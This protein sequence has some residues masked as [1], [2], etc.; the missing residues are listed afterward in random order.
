MSFFDDVSRKV[1][2][3]AEEW[4]VQGKAEKLAAEVDKVAHEAKDKAAELADDNRGKIRENLDKA[5]AKIDER[6]EGKYADKVAKA[7][8]TVAGGVDKLAEQRPGGP[9]PPG[10]DA[11]RRLRPAPRPRPRRHTRRQLRTAVPCRSPSTSPS[12]STSR[13][14]VPA[15]RRTSRRDPSFSDGTGHERSEFRPLGPG[16]VRLTGTGPACKTSLGSMPTMPAVRLMPT[17]DAP[18]PHRPDPR[19]LRQGP[20]APGRRD[21][22]GGASS[23]PADTFRLLGKTGLLSLPYPEE[24]G[25]GGQPYEVYLQVVEEIAS[26]WMSVAVGVSVHSLTCYP[27]ASWGSRRAARGPAARHARRRPARRLLPQRADVR[28]RRRRR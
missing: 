28:L 8:E 11:R 4:D 13:A 17:E 7:K 10:T 26:V 9:V 18:G 19:D 12:R 21:G 27:V 2:Q 25:G 20:R 16:P 22:T 23:R 6:T 3:K 5:G 1:K 14:P 15:G 24:Y